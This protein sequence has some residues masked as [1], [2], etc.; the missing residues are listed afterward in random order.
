[1]LTTEQAIAKT[2]KALL[3]NEARSATLVLSE[4][5]TVVVTRRRYG[6]NKRFDRYVLDLVVTVGRPNARNREF[7]Q[8]AKVAGEPFPIKRI[9]LRF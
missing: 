6:K 3:A 2:T 1:M 7:I 8:R 5:Q 4:K 9:Q